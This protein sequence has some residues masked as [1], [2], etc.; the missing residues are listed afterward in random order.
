M[1]ALPAKSSAEALTTRGLAVAVWGIAGIALV[2]VDALWRLVPL[3]VAPLRSG[4]LTK[5]Q[6]LLYAAWVLFTAYA[7]GYR[8]FQLRFAPSCAA[9]A[10]NLAHAQSQSQSQPMARSPSLLNAILAPA[11]CMGLFS[12]PRR[13]LLT[14]W[15]LVVGITWLVL[16]VKLLPQPWRGV[17]DGGVVV[18]LS[19]GLVAVLASA[20]STFRVALARRG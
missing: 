14:S 13:R 12:A 8:G 11:Y 1:D 4:E 17:V 19:W 20:V 7:E 6:S 5:V 18:G 15:L 9:R 10:L 3:A 2:L 16:L